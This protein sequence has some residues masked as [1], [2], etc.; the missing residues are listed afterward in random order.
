M[1]AG[2]SD[3]AFLEWGG[4]P[5][6]ARAARPPAVRSLARRLARHPAFLAGAAVTMFWI[7][8]AVG[9][10]LI[11]P[12]DPAAVGPAHTLA[13]P[14]AAHWLGTDDLGRDVFSR[15]LA[16]AEPVL[17][18]APVATV[19]SVLGGVTIGL[20]AGYTRG[21]LDDV[22][23][24]LVDAVMSLPVIIPATLVLALVGR[25][26]LN[27][28]VVIALLFSPLVARTVRSAVLVE[29]ER[30]Y[31]D[32][33][34]LRGDRSAYIMLFEILPNVAA[35]ILVEATVR[36]GYAVFTAGTLSFLQLGI[37]PPSP[38][39]GLTVALERT[40]V[41]IAP[42]TVLSPALALASLIV[43][44]NLAADGLRQVLAE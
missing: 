36:L 26:L 3:Q 34:R 33:A 35:P 37:Q 42:W 43:G 40:F 15:V 13:P 25:T 9:W 16:G 11:V 18:V 4:L 27:V 23:M 2:P 22:L 28:T 24:R 17:V 19:L 20:V 12:Y 44:V 29:R 32:A 5:A 39:W 8:A 1:S 21:L 30:E 38:D 7:V 41:Q 14:G 10:R 6:G 31:V